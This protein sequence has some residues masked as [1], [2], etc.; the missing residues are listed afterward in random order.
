ME[1]GPREDI[2]MIHLN[3][4]DPRE[5]INMVNTN[6]SL[7]SLHEDIEYAEYRPILWGAPL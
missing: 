3:G 2:N 5:D 4:G 6:I 7:C 1:S